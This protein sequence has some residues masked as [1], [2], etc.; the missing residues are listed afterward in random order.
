MLSPTVIGIAFGVMAA[1]CWA[2]AFAFAKHGIANGMAPA[3]LV[4]HRFAWSGALLLPFVA[5]QGLSDL[6]GVGWRRSIALMLF[7]GPLQA[8]LAYFGFSIVPLGHGTVIQPATAA[9]MGV[10]LSAWILREHL[11]VVRIAG[12]VIIVIGLLIFGA[13]ALSTIGTHGA[14]GDL[15]FVSAGTL[16]AC[17]SV[18]L[19]RWSVSGTHAMIVVAVLSLFIIVPLHGIVFGYQS[20]IAAGLTENLVQAFVQG[21]LGGALPIYLYARSVSILGAGRAS[22]FVTLVP[23]FSVALGI[24]LIGEIPTA[25]RL[26]GLAIVLIGFRF[27]LKP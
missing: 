7:A 13:E 19:R 18:A 14:G 16:W 11:S 9:S 4:L 15:L 1:F 26:I 20:M 21:F 24:V 5:Q 27:A 6:G 23:V 10:L 22:M 17:F 3:D 8:F 2:M 25:M 12:V